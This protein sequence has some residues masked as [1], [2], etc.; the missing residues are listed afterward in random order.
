MGSIHL[1]GHVSHSTLCHLPYQNTVSPLLNLVSSELIEG[2]KGSV[3]GL[4][5]RVVLHDPL[6]TPRSTGFCLGCTLQCCPL[7]F[8]DHLDIV[9]SRQLVIAHKALVGTPVTLDHVIHY[10]VCVVQPCDP[11]VFPRI[12]DFTISVPGE[13]LVL[14]S[15]HAAGQGDLAAHTAFNLPGTDGGFQRLWG[16]G[17]GERKNKTSLGVDIT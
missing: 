5:L 17:E 2:K 9:L 6:P 14:I 13:F 4:P 7:T 3:A 11:H 1:P 8:K 15:R 12:E 10:K 16:V